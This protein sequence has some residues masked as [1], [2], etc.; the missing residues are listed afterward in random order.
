MTNERKPQPDGIAV[1]G[2][3]GGLL[4]LSAKMVRAPRTTNGDVR[5]G[6]ADA[7]SARPPMAEELRLAGRQELP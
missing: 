5:F 6:R 1:I 2:E 4:R 7:R 3:A